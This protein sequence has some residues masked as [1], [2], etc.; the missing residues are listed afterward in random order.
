MVIKALGVV[1]DQASDVNNPVVH[2]FGSV[3]GHHDPVVVSVGASVVVSVTDGVAPVV[4]SVVAS[5]VDSVDD[6]VFHHPGPPFRD[7][8]VD[9]GPVV[10]YL[11]VC[12]LMFI[13]H[14][15]W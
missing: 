7:N 6:P 1:M 10:L 14:L 11:C 4:V 15:K 9:G 12:V 8:V 5:V 3:H 13:K 2:P